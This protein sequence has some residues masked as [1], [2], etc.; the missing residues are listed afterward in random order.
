MMEEIQNIG[1]PEDN[2]EVEVKELV[3][4]TETAEEQPEQEPKDAPEEESVE[5]DKGRLS[6]LLPPS[7]SMMGQRPA[8]DSMIKSCKA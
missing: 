6:V 7:P 8:T 5:K 2:P 1:Q 3:S 4:E